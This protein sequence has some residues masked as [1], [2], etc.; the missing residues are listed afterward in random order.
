MKNDETLY[1]RLA[2]GDRIRE[3]RVLLGLTQDELSERI[4]RVPKYCA[5]IERGSC[6][7]SIE[8]MISFSRTLDMPLDYLM[9]GRASDEMK[10]AQHDETRSIMLL[11]E[12]CSAQNRHY[13]LELLKLFLAACEQEKG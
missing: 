13:A 1:D 6:G 5:D 3:K 4:N 7:M 8:T 10:Q 9:F 11:L 12:R 2:V